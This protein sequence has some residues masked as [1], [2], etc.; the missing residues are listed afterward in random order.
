MTFFFFVVRVSLSGMECERLSDRKLNFLVETFQGE[1]CQ[2]LH[3]FGD[4]R[5]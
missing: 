5:V 3:N 1:V 2:K 4:L